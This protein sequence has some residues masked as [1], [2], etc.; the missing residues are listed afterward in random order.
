MERLGKNKKRASCQGVAS[1]DSI[2]SIRHKF[3]TGPSAGK[4]FHAG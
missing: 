3:I 4:D 2:E 1:E